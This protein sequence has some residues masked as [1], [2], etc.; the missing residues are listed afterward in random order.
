VNPFVELRTI[1]RLRRIYRRERPDLAHHFTI[2]CVLY[3]SLAVK[4]WS[5][6]TAVVN[7]VP[8]QGYMF[9]SEAWAA[10]LLRPFVRWLYRVALSGQKSRVIFQNQQDLNSFVENAL[11]EKMSARL[12]R[13]SGVDC[14][15]FSPNVHHGK[16]RN[17]G[18]VR[19]LFA[20]RMLIDK[21]VFELL[22]AARTILRQGHDV[23]FLFAGDIYPNN[24]SS[25]TKSDI[26]KIKSEGVVDYLGHVEDMPSLINSC[27]I[28]VLPSYA[29]GTP[30]ILLEAAAMEKPIVATN[31]AG[32]QRL[33]IDGVNGILVPVKDPDALC[34][35]IMKLACDADLRRR[36]GR[37]GRE[38]VLRE[39]DDR[40]VL[41]ETLEVY[42]E[43]IPE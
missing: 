18:N 28:V 3:G 13:G 7:A 9:T 20:A 15:L 4:L 39:F 23:D 6:Q 5:C 38:I 33:V 25:L 40:N 36:Y 8:G 29:E 22:E 24:P 2:K 14:V 11:V 16:F 43:M 37:A 42:R 17:G 34:E 1:L 19:V 32:C 30:K 21:G 31:I 10:K 41:R 26:A 12:I 27:D 35:A